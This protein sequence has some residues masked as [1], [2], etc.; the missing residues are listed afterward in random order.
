MILD[1]NTPEH[2]A[3]MDVFEEKYAGTWGER[4]E[5]GWRGPLNFARIIGNP[6]SDVPDW[7]VRLVVYEAHDTNKLFLAFRAGYEVGRKG[8]VG[9]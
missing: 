7:D 8:E 3:L 5:R 6:H 1:I 9:K 4:D 2:D